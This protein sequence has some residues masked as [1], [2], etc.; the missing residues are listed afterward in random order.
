MDPYRLSVA[1]HLVFS[2]LLVG[3][4]LFWVIMRIA[5]ARGRAP[6][7]SLRLLGIAQGA[8]WPHVVVPHSL[9]IPI[10]WLTWL[11]VAGL[12][13]S[14]FLG[15]SLGS[16]AVSGV[17]WPKWLL[18]GIVTALQ[19]AMTLRVRPAL[20]APQLALLLATIAVSG[21]LTRFA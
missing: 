10:P 11:V 12:W 2:I 3:L 14:G 1:L 15:A 8:R 18:V 4:A 17:W 6:A 16:H 9:R 21:W 7:E 20:F 13:A 19:L 5:L